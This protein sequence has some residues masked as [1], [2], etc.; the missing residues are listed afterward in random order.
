LKDFILRRKLWDTLLHRGSPKEVIPHFQPSRHSEAT[1]T[2]V[3]RS[4]LVL[5][6]MAGLGFILAGLVLEACRMQEL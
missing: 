1:A 5:K 4:Q 3:Q 2:V 6:L